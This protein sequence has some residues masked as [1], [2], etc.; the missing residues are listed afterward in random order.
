MSISGYE[1][2]NLAFLN[3]KVYKLKMS[4]RLIGWAPEHPKRLPIMS[5]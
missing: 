5:D 2:R 3:H 4:L 1:S